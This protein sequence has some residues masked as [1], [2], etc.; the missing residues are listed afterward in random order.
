M[1]VLAVVAVAMEFAVSVMSKEGTMNKND[2]M[3]RSAVTAVLHTIGAIVTDAAA[4]ACQ[5]T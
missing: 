2:S 5:P 4:W 1:V 3:T